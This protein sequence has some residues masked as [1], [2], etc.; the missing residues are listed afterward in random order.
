MMQNYRALDLTDGEAQLCGRLLG[1]MGIDVIRVEK[2]GGDSSRNTGP[3][4]KDSIHPEKNLWW[5]ILNANKRGITLNLESREGQQICKKL[6]KNTDFIIESYPP[7]YMTGLGLDYAA[8]KEINPRIIVTS[9]T[10]FG[11]TG[12]YK[13]Y[14]YSELV[15]MALGV[16]MFV[17]GD[18]DR[19][20]VKP[21]YPLAG[22]ASAIHA[23][24]AMLIASYYR[25]KSG[26]GQYIDVSTQ[27]G[28]PWFT[29]SVSS[30][31]QMERREM[32]RTGSAMARR[33]DLYTRFIWPCKDGYV[34]FQL[35]GGAVGLR[36]NKALAEWMAESGI[37][38]EFF[39]N[40][41]WEKLNLYQ[42][43][44]EL[45]DKLE[46]TIQ[47]FFMTKGKLELTEESTK[48]GILLGYIGEMS[49]LFQNPQLASRNFWKKIEHPELNRA[50]TYPGSFARSSAMG[51]GTR[52]RAPL[53]G[54]HNEEVYE[55]IGISKEQLILLNQAGVI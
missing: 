16:F 9:M 14:K 13:D 26:E 43:S 42:D 22:I 18:P 28:I 4:Y 44:Q 29:G 49:D 51:W 33:P 32:T 5:F 30:W 41:N 38:D 27:A 37:K 40:V 47:A 17:T 23:A 45:I 39:S 12:P 50:L 2:P 21:N 19:P 48:R 53:I 35:F 55:E 6:I 1:D 25:T 24:S 20:P 52:Q 7:G 34:L 54:E 31:W 10:P 46:K 11:Q 3:F 8:L 15:L 36:S